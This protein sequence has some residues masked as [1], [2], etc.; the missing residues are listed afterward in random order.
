MNI[1]YV[2]VIAVIALL[3]FIGFNSYQSAQY[4]KAMNERQAETA[5]LLAQSAPQQNLVKANNEPVAKMQ[6]PSAELL[7]VATEQPKP[8]NKI[9]SSICKSVLTLAENTMSNR[10][11]EVPIA[12]SLEI[13]EG[14]SDGTA[15]NDAVSEVSKQIVIDAYKQPYFSTDE[16]K[17]TAIREFGSQQYLACVKAFS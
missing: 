10:Q 9:D 1:K 5:E 17:Q 4:K 15:A 14:I 13:A 12:K 3:G 11:N 8:N 2:A 16:Y 7:P 6:A